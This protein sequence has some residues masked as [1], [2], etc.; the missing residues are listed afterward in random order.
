MHGDTFKKNAHC[1]TVCNNK[2]WEAVQIFIN[3]EWVNKWWFIHIMSYCTTEETNGPQLY[4]SLWIILKNILLRGKKG[5]Q[6][7]LCYFSKTSYKKQ[8]IFGLG[9]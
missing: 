6:K 3:R 5:F 7:V 8:Y 2:K 4:I 9:I 1:N